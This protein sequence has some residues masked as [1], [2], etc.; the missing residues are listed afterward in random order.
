MQENVKKSEPKL[1]SLSKGFEEVIAVQGDYILQIEKAIGDISKPEI[2][3]ETSKTEVAT[4]MP[5]SFASSMEQLL[6]R[7][8]KNNTRLNKMVNHL[9]T[10]I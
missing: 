10:I 4:E 5:N 7:L 8:I 2:E 1:V 9:D 6:D 3:K